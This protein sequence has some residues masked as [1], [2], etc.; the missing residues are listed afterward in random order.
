[1]FC[2]FIQLS[3][4]CHMSQVFNT[5]AMMLVKLSCEPTVLV[6]KKLASSWM[7]TMS[8]SKILQNDIGFSSYI[9]SLL[10]VIGSPTVH[11]CEAS[12]NSDLKSIAKFYYLY[13]FASLPMTYFYVEGRPQIPLVPN[14]Y[15][16]QRHNT[17]RS[18]RASLAR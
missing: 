6:I 4:V 13:L 9:V 15:C 18:G 1:M 11:L 12:H 14:P 17:T 5:D 16:V 8:S 10:P 2:V 7:Q 3:L